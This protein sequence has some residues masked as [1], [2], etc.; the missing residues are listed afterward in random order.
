[1]KGGA[2]KAVLLTR[3]T[4]APFEQQQSVTV[5][6]SYRFTE[7]ESGVYSLKLLGTSVIRPDILLDGRNEA[8]IDLAVPGWGW[9]ASDAGISPGFGIVRCRV[10]DHTNLPVHLWTSG[11]PGIVLRT[12]SKQEYGSDT[13]EFA[14]LGAGVYQ[15]QA[16]GV[17]AIAEV[18]VDGSRIIWVTFKEQPEP[19]TVIPSASTVHGVVRGAAGPAGLYFQVRLA[20]PDGEQ[21]AATTSDGVFQFA[22]LPAGVYSVSIDAAQ[23]TREDIALD[24]HNTVTVELRAPD[25]AEGAIFGTVAHGGGRLIRLWL[26]PLAS[27]LLEQRAGAAG[28]YRFDKLAAGIYLVDVAAGDPANGPEA[29]LPNI[30]IDGSTA[31]QLDLALPAP[32][33]IECWMA[34][35]EDGGP[36]PGFSIVRC[37][38]EG[39]PDREVH[40]WTHGWSGVVR[41]TGTKP[42]YGA[43]V[44]EFAPLSAGRYQVEP[45]GLSAP[46]SQPVR[47]EIDLGADRVSWVRFA[48]TTEPTA[49]IERRY[50]A[51]QG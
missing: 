24:G 16:E 4:G 43:D 30:L 28:A 31:I 18:A 12:G 26:P 29:E 25:A 21:T 6:G 27:P 8:V 41:R 51:V 33:P 38:V 47:A 39:E 36:G 23:V 11:W 50:V 48:R 35:I 2:G 37:R 44:C 17:D 3:H 40:L 19:L 20:G 49:S 22:G 42:E 34:T 14:P 5:D 15:V 9:E 10:V 13:C 1:V 45:A 7:L 46:D 32:P